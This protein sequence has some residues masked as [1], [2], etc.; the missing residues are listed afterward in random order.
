MNKS[1]YPGWNY[2]VYSIPLKN[3]IR[4]NTQN[5]NAKHLQCQCIILGRSCGPSP[6]IFD[7]YVFFSG[8]QFEKAGFENLKQSLYL[9]NLWFLISTTVSTNQL[10]T[11]LNIALCL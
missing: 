1:I 10:Y 5:V 2:P 6:H 4:H 9:C 11:F 7:I 3:K 8:Q